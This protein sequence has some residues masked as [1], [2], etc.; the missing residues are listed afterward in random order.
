MGWQHKAPVSAVSAVSPVYIAL[1]R[2]CQQRDDWSHM[3]LIYCRACVC[4]CFHSLLD[5]T[6][7]FT[8]LHARQIVDY[9]VCQHMQLLFLSCERNKTDGETCLPGKSTLKK[10]INAVKMQVYNLVKCVSWHAHF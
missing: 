8:Y 7:S 4:V 9:V 1:C 6:L 2:N 5:A 10:Y 3:P